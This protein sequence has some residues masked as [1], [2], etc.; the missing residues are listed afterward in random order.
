MIKYLITAALALAVAMPL[1]AEEKAPKAP[2]EHKEKEAREAKS[3][4]RTEKRDGEVEKRQTNQEHRIEHGIENGSLTPDESS[5]LKS[6]QDSIEQLQKKYDSDGK[7]SKDEFKD[8]Q[9]HLNSLSQDI[10]LEKHDTEGHQMAVRRLGDGR[11]VYLNKEL[12]EKFEAGN[13]SPEESKAL[14]KDLRRMCELRAQLGG[15]DK[16]ASADARSKLQSEYND[17][18]NK[19]F[20]KGDKETLSEEEKVKQAERKAKWEAMTPEERAAVKAK[21]E[22]ENKKL[23]DWDN[24]SKEEKERINHF[25]KFLSEHASPEQQAHIREKLSGMTND[26]RFNFMKHLMQKARER[27]EKKIEGGDK[28]SGENK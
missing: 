25:H 1:L 12:T 27:A 26:E 14:M 13:L 18:L 23:W 3:E 19:Y 16:V 10:F 21:N 15:K 6:R 11:S 28:S 2:K 20:T 5:K 7:I 17:L 24:L 4:E 8:L 22:G 9:Q